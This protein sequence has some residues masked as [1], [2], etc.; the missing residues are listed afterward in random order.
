[1][2]KGKK[3]LPVLILSALAAGELTL[4]VDV[5]IAWLGG[6]TSR[7]VFFG[8]FVL[9]MAGFFW[10]P[11][12]T[13]K[14][15]IAASV[16]IP[17]AAVT[18]ALLCLLIWKPFSTGG[19]YR[20]TDSG[21]TQLYAQRRVMLIVPHEDDEI[22]VLGGVLEEYVTYGSQVYPVFVTNGDYSGLAE[23]RF[24]EAVA[25][26]EYIGIPEEN[27]IFLGYGDQWK[28]GGPHIYNA[29][30]GVVMESN[31]GRTET[32]G[33]RTG[34]A[35]REGRA[36]TIENLLEDMEAVILQYRP[37]V[38]ICSDYDAHIDHRATS[39][40]FE[41]VMGT[42]LKEVPDYRPLVF[43]GY[44]YK[45][46]W[47]AESDF[48]EENILSTQNVFDDPYWQKPEVY[49]WE[50]RVRFPVKADALSRSLYTSDIYRTLALHASQEA[51][52]QASRVV[53]GDRVVWQRETESLCYDAEITVSSGGGA[54]LN[55]FMLTDNF[56]LTDEER[57]PYDGTWIPA[58]EDAERTV[59]VTFPE[60]RDIAR[61]RLYDHPSEEE[62]VL[63]AVIRFDD[64]SLLHTGP[65]D[66]GGAYTE[67]AVNKNAVRSF[68]VTLTE[69]E[70]EQPGLTEVEAFSEAAQDPFRFIKLMDAE[71]NFVYDYWLNREG[72]EAFTLYAQG[73]DAGEEYLVSCDN[74]RCEALLEN[75]V[76]TVRC[77][78][79]ETAVITVSCRGG[80]IADSVCVSN[81]GTLQR[82]HNMLGQKLEEFFLQG[83]LDGRH[84][85]TMTY[86]ILDILRYRLEKLAG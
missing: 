38:I 19:G 5:G 18:A 16:G 48:Y 69:T 86:E 71:E 75:G 27:V 26:A 32:Y 67:I 50:D 31:N 57:K 2:E 73:L 13:K 46:A 55:D 54:V 22:N 37:D 47:Y 10:I 15:L 59:S 23:A 66:P 24:A 68:T 56:D 3:K 35:F 14:R 85:Q 21:K 12:F 52:T 78:R 28:A 4:L 44:A 53:N 64:G 70:G 8:C 20:N 49:R 81:P 77:P 6:E 65:L 80:E 34:A 51:N 41:K 30:P 63:D 11:W 60:E 43:K 17:G 76:L 40:L 79:G 74:D 62:N 9:L 83:W 33:T 58:A 7:A 1:M 72:E 25:V 61:I 42:I 29:Q 45:T 84:R 36:Y 82:L 39:L